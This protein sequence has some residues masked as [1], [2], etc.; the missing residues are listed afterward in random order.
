M[1]I[2]IF[3]ADDKTKITWEFRSRRSV[4]RMAEKGGG[5]FLNETFATLFDARMHCQTLLA[6]NPDAILYLFDG[7]F[8]LDLREEPVQTV[9][10]QRAENLKICAITSVVIALIS[11]CVAVLL[12]G[13]VNPLSHVLFILAILGFYWLSYF[14]N[15]GNNGESV[16]SV[17]M[18]LIL[19]W[20]GIPKLRKVMGIQNRIEII[21]Q[22]R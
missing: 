19:A 14:A 9:A 13:F 22:S 12:I 8:F 15:A 17:I 5:E 21:S 6:R 7:E 16:I 1:K 11:Y 10:E 2:K 4:G 18:I 3:R 20:V